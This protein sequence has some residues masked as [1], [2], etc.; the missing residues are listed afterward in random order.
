MCRLLRIR[1]YLDNVTAYITDPVKAREV[2]L[3]LQD[4]LEEAVAEV[5]V[6]GLDAES[7]ELV[8]VSR[9]GP[10]ADLALQLGATHH[11]HLPWRFYLSPI[12]LLGLLVIPDKFGPWVYLCLWATLFFTLVPDGATRKRCLWLIYVDCLA[13]Y[14]WL[15]RQPLRVTLVSGGVAG[16]TAGLAFSMIPVVS[17]LMYSTGWYAHVIP[18]VLWPVLGRWSLFLV[19]LVPLVLASIALTIARRF[20]KGD[21]VL[22]G[23]CAAL[24]FPLGSLPSLYWL[25]NEASLWVFFNVT[26]A[27]VAL[28]AGWGARSARQRRLSGA[29]Q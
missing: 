28:L 21:W 24:G 17:D 4:H 19:L 3:E 15:K 20:L 9:M 8:V 26:F 10:P 6:Q 27:L 5:T 23:A 12:P 2:R 22:T 1:E 11:T 25:G 13:K 18:A 16:L 7:A 14:H 29:G